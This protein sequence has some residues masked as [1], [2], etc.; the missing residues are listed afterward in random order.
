MNWLRG[1]ALAASWPA[2]WD[3]VATKLAR[4]VVIVVLPLLSLVLLRARP[5]A[6]G[7]GLGCWR[8]WLP[9][10]AILYLLMLPLVAW[11][12]TRPSF[13]R[14]Y[15]YFA[16][17]RL[18][19]GWFVFGLAVRLCYMFCWEF[20]FRGYL[21]FGFERRVGAVAAI[22]VSTVPFVLMHFGKPLPEL[23]GSVVAGLVLGFVAVRG[24]SF[25]P[26]AILHFAVAATLDVAA[27]LAG[28]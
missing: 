3:Q 5:G 9:D 15:P 16:L 1:T 20:L 10:I 26:C 27:L 17:Q 25:I 12:A 24:R 19:P 28:T 23:Y 8:K 22:G 11:A 6:F 2:G 14:V 4:G 13:Q 7:V 21:L 18:G